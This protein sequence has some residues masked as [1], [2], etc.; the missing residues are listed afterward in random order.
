MVNPKDIEEGPDGTIIP[1]NIIFK[2]LSLVAVPADQ[3]AT[4]N[5]SMNQAY[6]AYKSE[7]EEEEEPEEELDDIEEKSLNNQ[8]TERRIN[9]DEQKTEIVEVA[10][11]EDK[12]A[13][14]IKAMTEKMDAMAKKISELES[15]KIIK[16]VKEVIVEKKEEKVE[17]E[18][19]EEESAYKILQGVGSLK[20]GS[21]TVIRNKY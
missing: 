21:F 6:K 3:G 18:E 13:D 20:G 7:D 8:I 1:H 9:M 12:S 11:V 4:F 19:A 2:E 16:E 17:V 5:I 14:L 15:V 10:K